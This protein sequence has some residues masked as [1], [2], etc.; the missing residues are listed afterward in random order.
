MHILRLRGLAAVA[1]LAV[2]C[3]STDG[4]PVAAPTLADAPTATVTTTTTPTVATPTGP[5]VGTATMQVRGGTGPVTIRYQINGGPEQTE[6]NVTLPWEKQYSVY[7]KLDTS[8]TADGGSTELICTIIMD[9]NLV[10][11]VTEPRPTCSF[12]YWG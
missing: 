2:G 6:S 11:F 3:S 7:D 10:A 8:V 4:T 5:P 9:G 1:A 12:A